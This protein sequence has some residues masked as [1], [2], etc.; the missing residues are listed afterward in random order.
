MGQLAPF[1]LSMCVCVCVVQEVDTFMHQCV[2]SMS[3]RQ[4]QYTMAWH[5]GFDSL[6]ARGRHKRF[7]TQLS[8]H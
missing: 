2:K 7:S 8:P 5:R 6:L 3:I 1:L 4:C